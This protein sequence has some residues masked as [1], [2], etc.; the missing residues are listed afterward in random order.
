MPAIG[1]ALPLLLRKETVL[2]V[3][4]LALCVVC[5]CVRELSE[6]SE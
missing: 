3:V 1:C 5:E 6:L 4:G 2:A